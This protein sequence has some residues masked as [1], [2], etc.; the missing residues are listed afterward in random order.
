MPD[1]GF[2]AED[3]PSCGHCVPEQR[4]IGEPCGVEHEVGVG[5]ERLI[6]GKAIDRLE[7]DGLRADED[8]GVEVW[9]QR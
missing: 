2:S 6:A 7:V 8:K 1:P 4:F 9:P 5:G 3:E